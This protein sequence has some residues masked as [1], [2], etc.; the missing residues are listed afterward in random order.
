M[1]LTKPCQS[2]WAFE[3]ESLGERELKG[4]QEPVKAYSV[5]AKL[6]VEAPEIGGRAR[7]ETG[8]NDLPERPSI[9]VLPF[10]NM[11]QDTEQDYFS[12]GLTEDII[13]ELSHHRDL[14]VTARHSSVCVPGSVGG[15]RGCGE[16][17][18]RALCA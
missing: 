18:E 11:S 14:F 3:Y 13:T 1:L 4:F 10:N 15:Y 6:E 7:A 16:E 2:A 8:G 9:A 5:S 17:I 12:D